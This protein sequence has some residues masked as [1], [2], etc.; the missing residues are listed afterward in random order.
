MPVKGR[1]GCTGKGKRPHS[2]VRYPT[3]SS[4]PG[5]QGGVL[6][7]DQHKLRVL[8]GVTKSP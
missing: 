5:P 6:L 3:P 2:G 8:G 4:Q 7:L 1:L